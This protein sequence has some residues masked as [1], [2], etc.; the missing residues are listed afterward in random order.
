[1]TTAEIT[2]KIEAVNRRIA[3]RELEIGETD[4]RIA[5]RKQEDARWEALNPTCYEDVCGLNWKPT[6][7]G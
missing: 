3:Q 1:M 4:R 5:N 2:R 7:R 6:K